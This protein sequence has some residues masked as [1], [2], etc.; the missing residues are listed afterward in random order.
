MRVI[1]LQ[2]EIPHVVDG[3]TVYAIRWRDDHVVAAGIHTVDPALAQ[4]DAVQSFPTPAPLTRGDTEAAADQSAQIGVIIC[5]HNRPQHLQTCLESFAHQI[6]PPAQIIVV[7]NAPTDERSKQVCD[8]FDVTYVREDRK[9]LSI[10]R[11][12]GL[13]HIT[14]DYVA[15]TDDDVILHPTWLSRMIDVFERTGS[16]ALT[17]LTLPV[18]LGARSQQI[19][20]QQWSF[21]RGLAPKTYSSNDFERHRKFCFPAWEIGAGANMAFRRQVFVDH[22][23][24]EEDLGAGAAGCSEDSELWYRLLGSGGTCVYDPSVIVFHTHRED[25][26]ALKTQLRAYMRGHTAALRIQGKKFPNCGNAHRRFITLPRWYA[27]LALARMREG[28]RPQTWFLLDEICGYLEGL[29]YPIK[30]R[31]ER[32]K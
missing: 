14:T 12:T 21:N 2:D 5:T 8:A 23:L 17:G 3:E 25:E 18:E 1:H 28:R 4:S 10:A 19:F 27:G 26:Q 32:V 6:V 30:S 9:G 24:F 16:D 11:N 31:Q 29:F 22:G 20:E 7:D 13:A 15:F